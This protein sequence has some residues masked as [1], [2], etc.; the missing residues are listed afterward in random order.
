MGV[1]ENFKTFCDD[2]TISTTKRTTISIRF[3]AIVK[4]LNND[5]WNLDST[6][7]GRYLGSYGR[8]T[9]NDR[10]SDVDMLF[11]MPWS[12]HAKYDKYISN[13]QSALL[14]DVKNSIAKT[15]P[16]TYLKG[17]GQ[18]V[19][20]TFWDSNKFEVL[21]AFKHTDN[22]Y[23]YGDSNSGGSWK[24]TNPI[25]EINAINSGDNL[26]NNNLKRLCKM[27]RAWKFHCDVPIKGLLIDTL[28]YRFLLSWEHRDKSYL[29]YDWMCRDFFAFLKNQT[30]TQTIWYAVGSMQSIYNPD[31]FR[32]KATIAYNK[33][34]DA[35]KLET[36]G[37][38]WST[39]QKWREIYG[40]RYPS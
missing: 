29:Y 23:T 10:V 16:S 19:Q 40:I 14:Q 30:S 7:G 28:A 24:K 17:D 20:V 11:E 35:I 27:T 3:N 2:L 22:T 1:S 38:H 32:Y 9:A 13:G 36:D 39:K 25:P 8:H 37:K 5:F 12:V 4:R 34:I 6:T 33:S 31:N 18:I 21:P 15:Y 26:T